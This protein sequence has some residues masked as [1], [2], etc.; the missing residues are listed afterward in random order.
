[1]DDYYV[2]FDLTTAD[3]DEEQNTHIDYLQIGI[4]EKIEGHVLV[5]EEGAVVDIF[6]DEEG[7]ELPITVL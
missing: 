4:G 1:M 6:Y 5:Y 2:V 7:E 3:H